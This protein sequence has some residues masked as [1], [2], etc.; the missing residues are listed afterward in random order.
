MFYTKHCEYIYIYISLL[1][2]HFEVLILFFLNTSYKVFKFY[3]IIKD[4]DKNLSVD[5][6]NKL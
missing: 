6:K 4:N 1:E 2:Y 3:C 5:S